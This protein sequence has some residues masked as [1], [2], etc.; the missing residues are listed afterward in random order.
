MKIFSSTEYNS[1]RSKP[2]YELVVINQWD[3]KTTPVCF[4]TSNGHIIS[5]S[6]CLNTPLNE[7]TAKHST[8]EK[9]TE[10]MKEE[11]TSQG[12]TLAKNQS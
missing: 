11:L 12:Y 5:Y 4:G 2:W 3:F 10:E 6:L 1:D 8:V 9:L 7:N